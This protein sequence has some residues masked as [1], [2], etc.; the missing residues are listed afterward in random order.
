MNL[1]QFKSWKLLYED[2]QQCFS[3]AIYENDETPAFLITIFNP[4]E[5]AIATKHMLNDH[6]HNFL[7]LIEDDGR[8]H[9][10]LKAISG[11]SLKKVLH[12]TQLTYE[13]RV[14]LA[15]T[16]LKNIETYDVFPDAIKIQLLDEE[17]LL[18]S[19]SGICFR[20]LI[21]YTL[22]ETYTSF[23]VFKQLGEILDQI[24][25][26][27]TGYHNQ[28]IDNLL[29]CKHPYQT[30]TEIKTGFKDVFIYEKPEI[31]E[32]IDTEYNIILN[33][34]DYGP[35]VHLSEIMKPIQQPILKKQTADIPHDDLQSELAALL[36]HEASKNIEPIETINSVMEPIATKEPIQ[37]TIDVTVD[38]TV[39]DIVGDIVDNTFLE[40]SINAQ[41]EEKNDAADEEANET[42]MPLDAETVMHA[43]ADIEPLFTYHES[44][45][46]KDKLP[47][48]LPKSTK[49]R[50]FDDEDLL[51]ED[52]SDLFDLG[53]PQNLKSFP[54]KPLLIILIGMVA[55]AVLYFGAQFFLNMNAPIKAQFEV[56]QLL[57]NRVAFMNT[58]E[59]KKKIEAYSWEIY[60]GDTLISTFSDENLFPLFD[61]SGTYTI[62]LKVM[63]KDET[64]Q[65]PYTFVYEFTKTQ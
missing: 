65:E 49:S 13:E 17:Q 4:E 21:D 6:L 22:Q 35:P 46:K 9:L 58:S 52:M 36:R 26:D 61:T 45:N 11:K 31:L 15:Y 55:L 30:L 28:F 43:P 18:I 63:D 10:A 47:E 7:G 5:V 24:L 8:I 16:Y 60:Y 37:E 3:K 54:F 44:A 56:E 53:E 1:K 39:G 2:D 12:N 41:A 57:D 25:H 32:Q 20:E 62:V 14:E 40:A 19:D 34:L 48:T 23:E 64:W 59:G 51:D 42:V 29:R 38:D 33:D 50:A 27:A